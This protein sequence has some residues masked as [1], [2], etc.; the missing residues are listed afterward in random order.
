MAIV[1]TIATRLQTIPSLA[2]VAMI[3]SDMGIYL[4]DRVPKTRGTW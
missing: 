3:V 4:K 1:L 2:H